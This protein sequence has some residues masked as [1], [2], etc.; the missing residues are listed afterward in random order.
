MRATMSIVPP[1]G[2]GTIIVTGLLVQALAASGRA[3]SAATAA[4]AFRRQRNVESGFTSMA[5]CSSKKGGGSGR[6]AQE[7]LMAALRVRR[8]A[9]RRQRLLDG[10][11]EDAD[12]ADLARLLGDGNLAAKLAADAHKLLDLLDGAHLLGARLVP[13]VVLDAAAHVQPHRDR[14]S[15]RL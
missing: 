8:E 14:K 13:Q 7:A 9:V 1:G 6:L 2:S 11:V 4:S 5:P 10:V 15:T 3:A 12:L